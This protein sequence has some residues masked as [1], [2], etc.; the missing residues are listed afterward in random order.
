MKAAIFRVVLACFFI[1]SAGL[2]CFADQPIRARKIDEF[3]YT[4]PY[5][6][7]DI[8]ARLDE[9]WKILSE[10]P[11]LRVYI[12]G[13]GGRRQPLSRVA[14]PPASWKQYLVEMR[15]VVGERVVVVTG[16]L[17]EEA[18][19]EVWAVPRGT[20]PPKPTPAVFPQVR[21]RR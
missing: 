17:R 14:Y 15:Q 18:L 6:D 13:Y 2:G 3:K 9:Y 1:A 11:E 8:T 19:V 7:C 4:L 21:R 12:I 16:G 5:S 10:N 20:E